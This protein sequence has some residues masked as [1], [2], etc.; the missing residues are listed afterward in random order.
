MADSTL[1]PHKRLDL[2][3]STPTLFPLPLTFNILHMRCTVDVIAS[4]TA[5][6]TVLLF[7][8]SLGSLFLVVASLL[9]DSFISLSPMAV[10]TRRKRYTHV[11]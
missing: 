11:L 5:L 3:R 1:F 10:S 2:Y 8:K 6:D 4:G 7:D 9:T